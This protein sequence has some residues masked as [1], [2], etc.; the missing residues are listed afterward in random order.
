MKAHRAGACRRRRRQVPGLRRNPRGP[1]RTSARTRSTRRPRGIGPK[2]SPAPA[3]ALPSRPATASRSRR[4]CGQGEHGGCRAKCPTRHHRAVVLGD[5][6]QDRGLLGL[7]EAPAPNDVA[8]GEHLTIQ[9]G[10]CQEPA[11]RVPPTL[12]LQGGDGG[13]V[14]GPASRIRATSTVRR[15]VTRRTAGRRSGRRRTHAGSRSRRTSSACPHGPGAV[16]R[17]R[18]PPPSRTPGR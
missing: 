15:P 8:V 3:A 17:R 12:D 5:E 10:V 1:R 13:S 9:V 11:I 16:R 14:G 18:R 6:R 2:C 4:A 7:T